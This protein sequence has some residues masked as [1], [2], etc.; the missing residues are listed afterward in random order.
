MIKKCVFMAVF[1]IFLTKSIKIEIFLYSINITQNDQDV[2][3]HAIT[4]AGLATQAPG[5]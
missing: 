3:I 5:G 2:R 1:I 4:C